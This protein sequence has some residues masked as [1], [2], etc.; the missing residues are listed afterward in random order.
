MRKKNNLEAKLFKKKYERI[1]KHISG[2]PSGEKHL[3]PFT[4][5][6]KPS[7]Y[8]ET[9]MD[10]KMDIPQNDE[11]FRNVIDANNEALGESGS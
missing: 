9:L 10:P 6:Y 2:I 11:L 3:N 4:S 7:V 8:T 1:A 5:P